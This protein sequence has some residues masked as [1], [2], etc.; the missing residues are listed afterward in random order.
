MSGAESKPP[1]SE[2][3]STEKALGSP[4]AVNLVPSNG[5][6]AISNLGPFNVPSFSPIYNI[7]ASSISP[8]PIT[9]VPSIFIL[10]NSLLIGST[11]PLSA[12]NLSFLPINLDAPIA[13]FSVTLV[14]KS[15][16]FLSIDINY[17]Q[18]VLI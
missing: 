14:N 16:N 1:F 9:T 2:I 8:S 3:A 10:F 13:A 5:S 7:G 4:F 17:H 11:A 12:A 15:K 6:T 18:Y